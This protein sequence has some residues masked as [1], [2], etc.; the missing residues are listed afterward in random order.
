MPEDA[1][2]GGFWRSA[3]GMLTAAA[4]I[5]TATAGLVAALSQAG[6]LR[7]EPE[8]RAETPVAIGGTW[9]AQVVYPW[10]LTQEETFSFRVE[11]DQVIGTATYLGAPRS[12]E[13]GHLAGATLS[14]STRAEEFLGDE[15]RSFE[16]RYDGMVTPRGINFVLQDTRGNGP[17][18]FTARRR[19]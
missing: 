17:I 7:P 10:D 11:E 1:K 19:E 13:A 8:A 2:S 15:R 18:E 9:T 3:P 6:F 5:I 16:N 12:I 4:G 14:F